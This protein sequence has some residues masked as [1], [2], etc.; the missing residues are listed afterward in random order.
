[1]SLAR[2]ALLAPH[3]TAGELHVARPEAT[4]QVVANA[5]TTASWLEAARGVLGTPLVVTS[6]FRTP[7]E[8]AAA[9]GD[10]DSDHLTGLAADFEARSLAPWDVYQLLTAA[11]KARQLPAFDQIIFYVADNHVH[12]GVGPRMRGEVLLK[13]TEGSYVALAGSYLTRLR[14]Y[15]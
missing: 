14:G 9:K 3:F 6:G 8:N 4:D 10:A 5:A 1:M 15:V 2:T 7:A 12:V 11:I 13:T